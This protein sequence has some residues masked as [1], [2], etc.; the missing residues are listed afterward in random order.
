ML[1][2]T[3][4]YLPLPELARFVIYYHLLNSGR[5]AT[6]GKHRFRPQPSDYNI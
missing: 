5:N 1:V 6:I 4:I 3:C 2:K